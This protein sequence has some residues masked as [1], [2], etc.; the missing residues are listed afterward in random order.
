MKDHPSG[1]PDEGSKEV[2]TYL[3][4]WRPP[5]AITR[6]VM[7]MARTPANVQKMAAVFTRKS[8]QRSHVVG[9]CQS[10]CVVTYIKDRQPLVAQRRDGVTEEGDG[11]EDEEHLP[12]LA[13]EDAIAL[14][15][16][17]HVDAGDEEEGR[18]E[19]DSER[20]GDVSDNEK[21]AAN[22]ARN[23]AP[24]GRGEHEGLVVD[25]CGRSRV[26]HLKLQFSCFVNRG[27]IARQSG[28]QSRTRGFIICTSG[29]GIDTGDFTQRRSDADDDHR[30]GDPSPDD[31]DGTSAD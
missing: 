26:N 17:E 27:E 16:G 2:K 12:V 1:Q 4:S 11:E 31:V 23:T 24:L 14:R 28:M 25:T 6:M 9:Y 3:A 15:V 20:D 10:R 29:S 18:S 13:R 7:M 5:F 8:A 22:P 19:V 21:P 30:H